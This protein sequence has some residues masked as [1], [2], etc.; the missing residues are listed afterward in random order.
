MYI[1][2]YVYVCKRILSPE[3][4]LQL[5]QAAGAARPPRPVWQYL[6][7]IC[8]CVCRCVSYKYVGVF[9]LTLTLNPICSYVELLELLALL[10]QSHSV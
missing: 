3:R 2:V 1:Y 5:R 7:N 8:V 10:G 6:N 4:P 9:G